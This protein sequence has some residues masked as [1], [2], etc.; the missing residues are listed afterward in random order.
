[1]RQNQ[2]C[3]RWEELWDEEQGRVAVNK[4]TRLGSRQATNCGALWI[5]IKQKK[6]SCVILRTTESISE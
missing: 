6:T 3:G 4:Y 5:K 1:M 2:S